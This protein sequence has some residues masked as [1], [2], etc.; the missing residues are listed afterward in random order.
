ML[1]LLSVALGRGGVLLLLLLLRLNLIDGGLVDER[2]EV[3][4]F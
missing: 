3:L 1:L 4:V 2:N